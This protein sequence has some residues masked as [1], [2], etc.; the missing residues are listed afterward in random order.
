MKIEVKKTDNNK[1]EISIEESGDI[2]K[3]KFDDV[4]TRISKDAKVPGFRPGNAPRDL[5]EKNFSQAAHE[6]ALKELI[7][8][9]YNQAIEKE[10]LDV[11]ELPEICEVK[12][13]R[14]TVSFKAKVELFPEIAVKDYKGVKINYQKIAVTEEEIKRGLD[15]LK[16][17]HKA[18]DLDDSFARSMGYPG[19]LQLKGALSRQ[20]EL[21]KDNAQRQKTER[22]IL[23]QVMK[24]L[25]FKLPKTMVDRQ[26][27]DLLRQAKIDLAL[28]GVPKEKIDAKESEFGKELLP[29]AEKQVRMYLVMAA[30]AKKEF[31]ATDDHLPQHV[32]EFLL[33][34]AEWNIENEAKS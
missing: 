23:D 2:V 7:P 19:L 16:E 27:E 28:K 10:G 24:G 1:R 4:F 11:I 12:L 21:Q 34:E 5:I 33:K 18:K 29:E 8:E 30:I 17:A 3:N 13:D 15:S 6:T 20:L 22:Q 32:M 26:L 31:I 25:D 9:L 14:T